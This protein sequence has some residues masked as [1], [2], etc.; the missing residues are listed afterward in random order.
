VPST[1]IF[2]TG[3]KCLCGADLKPGDCLET[4]IWKV[5]TKDGMNEII[6]KTIVQSDQRPALS[7]VVLACHLLSILQL[8]LRN[9]SNGYATIKQANA[10]K[11]RLW[12]G[13]GKE[14]L[15]LIISASQI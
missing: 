3:T 12:P 1:H 13:T 10:E 6:S 8:T 15:S 14:F 5:S 9:K 4:R 11:S 7:V 2:Q